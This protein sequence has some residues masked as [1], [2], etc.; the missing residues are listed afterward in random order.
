MSSVGSV[1]HATA[2]IPRERAKTGTGEIAGMR[3]R[4]ILQ[5][6]PFFVGTMST[7]D[8]LRSARVDGVL[9]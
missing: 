1:S 5:V 9:T 4:D 3:E 7:I 2:H 6:P 8:A